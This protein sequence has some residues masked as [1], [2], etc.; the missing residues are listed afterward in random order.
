MHDHCSA[1]TMNIEG[2]IE[3]QRT[4]VTLRRNPFE[5]VVGCFVRGWASEG[6]DLPYYPT[7]QLGN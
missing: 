1:E 7:T 6:K 4:A 5:R 2:L 3:A